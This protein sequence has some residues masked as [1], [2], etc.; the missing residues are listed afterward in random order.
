MCL[1]QYYRGDSMY[2]LFK[3]SISVILLG[4]ILIITGLMLAYFDITDIIAILGYCVAA[5]GLLLFAIYFVIFL[6]RE[7]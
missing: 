1:S 6:W 3:L 5:I 2:L 4:I 7:F